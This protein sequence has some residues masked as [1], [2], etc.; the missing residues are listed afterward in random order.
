MSMVG[1]EQVKAHFLAVKEKVDTAKR[2]NRSIKDWTFDLLIH[3][4]NGTGR[5]LTSRLL[6][7]F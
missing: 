2:W 6:P 4:R 7:C 3:G 5:F 1:H